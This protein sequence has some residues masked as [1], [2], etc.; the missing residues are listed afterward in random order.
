MKKFI[1]YCY[2]LIFSLFILIISFASSYGQRNPILGAGNSYVNISKRNTGGVVQSGDTLE[3]RTTYFFN[4]TYNAANSNYLYK[5][6]YYDSVPL[7]TTMLTTSTDS[8]RLITNEGV[9]FRKYTLAASDDPGTY[10]VAP[11]AGKYQIRINIGQ[12]NLAPPGI[13]TSPNEGTLTDI[14]GAGDARIGSGTARYKPQLFSGLLITTAFR[15]RVT[16][17]AGDTV[18]LAAGKLIYRKTSGGTDTIINATPYKIL[19]SSNNATGLCG[20]ALGPNLAFEYGGTFDSG[21]VQNRLAGP[22]FIIP[23]YDYKILTRAA[24]IGDGNYGFVNNLSPTQAINFYA[25][26]QPNCNIPAGAIPAADSCVHRMFGGH[27]DIIGDHTGTN[28]AA[29][30]PATVSGSKGGYML[31]VNSDVVT[32]EAYR[33][34]VT[35]LCPDTYY[36]FSAW[37]RNI[38]KTCGIDS[39]S[40]SIFNPGA[41]PNLAFSIN[42]LDIYS[43]GQLDTVGWQKK[44]F[45]FKTAPGQTSATFSIRN[46]APGGG[47]NDW[48]MDDVALGTC[49]P[50]MS[51]NFKPVFL[52]C[53]NGAVADLSDTV[54]YSYNPNY[55]WY[56]WERSTDNGVTWG[57][58]PV[59][60]SG[61]VSPVL[62]NGYYQFVTNYPQFVAHGADSGNLYRVVVATQNSNLSSSSCSFTDGNAIFLKI[63]T[64]PPVVEASLIS[65]TGSL[66]RDHKS[67]LNWLVSSE[68]NITRYE[69]EKSSDGINFR[70]AGE[71]KTS[72]PSALSEYIFND[73]EIVSGN[74]YFRIKIYNSNGL[75]KYSKVI[76]LSHGFNFEVNSLLNPFSSTISADII[77]PNNG[78]LKMNLFDSYGK[79]VGRENKKLTKGLTKVAYYGLSNLSKGMYFVSFEF[80]NAIVQKKLTKTN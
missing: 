47:G 46:N 7:K 53:S 20:N 54:R 75:Y 3:I 43:T 48:A 70:I 23:N 76:M 64:C 9:T 21:T 68:T 35:G 80:N 1:P 32:S 78:V 33:Q 71:K 12:H 49:G 38:C 77:L 27:W 11:G 18:V 14:T 39:N 51:M 17:I 79:L 66:Q 59:P 10:K 72:N 45:V 69:V 42:D 30:N 2:N 57:P 28:N 44:G 16:G 13:P 15:V 63:I 62:V 37:L 60:T 67:I 19:I 52:G 29:G 26:R 65:F 40:T 25:R 8:L 5:V 58:P 74:T 24:P 73:P 6:R 31:V 56:Q 4:S 36:E 50:S 22:A 41:L 61:S 34:S 55:S